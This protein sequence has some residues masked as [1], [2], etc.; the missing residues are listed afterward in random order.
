MLRYLL[1]AVAFA[2]LA[3][4]GAAEASK[5]GACTAEGTSLDSGDCPDDGFVAADHC[6]T[7]KRAACE[8]LACPPSRC[9]ATEGG[10]SKVSCGLN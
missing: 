10:P 7:S 3:A 4:C 2:P 6:F 5:L 8:C 1:L 9:T